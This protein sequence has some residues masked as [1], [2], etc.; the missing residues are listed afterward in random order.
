MLGGLFI[1]ATAI[2]VLAPSVAAS[3]TFV[4]NKTGDAADN[5]VGNGKCDTSSATGKQCT[6]RAAIQEANATTGGDFINFNLK[7]S[8]KVIAPA[9]PLPAITEQLTINGYS[10][11]GATANTKATGSDAVLKIVLD[12]VNAGAGANGL[13][14]GG[15]KSV[16]KG[17]VIQRFDGCGLL[18][19]GQTDQVYGN[20]VGTT[21]PGTA[22]RANGIGIKMTGIQGY[23]GD[24]AL[25]DR[26]VISG[27]NTQGV[28]ITGSAATGNHVY[29]NYI[30]TDKT[31]SAALGN[32]D[33][34]VKIED[35]PVTRIGSTSSGARNVISGNNFG[36]TIEGANATGTVIT[37][38]YIG[39][40]AA[41]TGDL[42]ND[43]TGIH[44]FEGSSTI[45]GDTPGERNVISGNDGS[46]ITIQSSN[47]VIQGNYVGVD[48]TGA[49]A[50]GNEGSGVTLDGSSNVLG[51]TTASVRNVIS[52]NRGD[53]V[54]ISIGGPNTVQGNRIGS[55]ADGTG[56]LGNGLDGISI[57]VSNDNIIGGS[58]AGAG[59]LITGSD[60]A[61]ISIDSS[62]QGSV[63]E[64]NSIVNNDGDGIHVER[65]S[66]TIR[67][68]SIVQNGGA[69][70]FVTS[71]ATS[72]RITANQMVA[73]GKLGIDLDGGS[74]NAFGVTSNDTDDPDTGPNTLQNY[75]VLTSAVR[76]NATGVTT[77]TGS[78]NSTPGTDFRIELFMAVAD[79]SGNGEA[80]AIIA[81]KNITTNSGGD[82]GFSFASSALAPGMVL[83]VT[84]TPVT[85]GSTSEFSANRTVAVGP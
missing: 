5:N 39:T 70:V 18:L 71:T 4:V 23:V 77:V 22:A 28:L 45:G 10:Q 1:A 82:K 13:E 21:T 65:G 12:G 9:T 73:N 24:S 47:N 80:L 79:S 50:L 34:G 52:A 68:N 42:G 75:P 11:S 81:F 74:Q 17:L 44:V 78:L 60:G 27:N 7:T 69:G 63:I 14:V 76:S 32:G 37:G 84:A 2:T 41:G 85:N 59:N 30:G 25:A 31:G 54:S 64:G 58:A 55:K 46:G 29:G 35:A 72:V 16:V 3:S 36:I 66:H 62:A 53:G 26:N 61:G 49:V 15:Y 43:Q 40:N 6:L 67:A 19:T 57:F 48:A 51:G 8:P 38:N 33:R 20:Y 56:D 83:T